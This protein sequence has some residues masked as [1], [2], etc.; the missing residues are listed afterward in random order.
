[1][2]LVNK[3]FG[4]LLLL[5]LTACSGRQHPVEYVPFKKAM[6]DRWGFMNLEGKVAQ[7]NKYVTCPSAVVNDC[8]NVQNKDGFWQLYSFSEQRLLSDRLFRSIGYFF[9]DV[10]IAVED[11]N[12]EIINKDGGLVAV[13]EPEIVKARNYSEGKAWVQFKNGTCGYIDKEGNEYPWTFNYASDFSDGVAIVGNYDKNKILHFSVINDSGK[14]LSRLS[15]DRIRILEHYHDGLLLYKDLST[16]NFG[17]IDK[18]GR[19]MTLTSERMEKIEQI[20]SGHTAFWMEGPTVSRMGSSFVLT[21]RNGKLL[22]EE[23]YAALVYDKYMERVLI[24]SFS[25]TLPTAEVPELK[26]KT[27]ESANAKGLLCQ[28]SLKVKDEIKSRLDAALKNMAASVQQASVDATDPAFRKVIR[29][30]V[31]CVRKAYED[32]NIGFLKQVFS[33][34]ALIIVGKVVK[35]ENS[36]GGFLSQKEIQYNV[37]TKQEYLRKL[38]SVFK[39]NHSIKLSFSQV[40]IARHPTKDGFYGVTLRQGYHS[41]KYSDEGYLFMLWDFRNPKLP[42]IHVRTWQPS[43]LD[44]THPLPEKD[45]FKLSNFTLE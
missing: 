2:N 6:S 12:L 10:T 30:Y 8:F 19:R 33:E 20:Q 4:F 28:D 41:D 24:Q 37:R 26:P 36:I 3:L 25:A 39:A 29:S 32:K 27:S 23:R 16:N 1:M 5:L 42:Q 35:K 34:D 18:E 45:I 9:D 17:F 13:L 15:V 43:M 22:S 40:K 31:E 44:S 7:V 14:V 11:N 38:G 21:D